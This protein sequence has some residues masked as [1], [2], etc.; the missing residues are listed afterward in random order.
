MHR[1]LPRTLFALLSLSATVRAGDDLDFFEKR[2]R[3][4]LVQRCEKCHGPD[5]QKGGLRL[6]SKAGWIRGGDRG[7]AIIPGKPDE[8]PLVRAVRHTDDDLAMP[9]H[10]AA[11]LSDGELTDLTD[12]VRRGAADPRGTV[13]TRL[14][15]MSL[16]EAKHW[17]S[18]QPLKRPDVP[19]S[20]EAGR[21]PIDAFLD[22]QILS[23]GITSTPRADKRTLIRRATFDLTGLPPTIEEVEAFQKDDSS[24]AFAKIVD[25]LLA[26]N[27]YGESWGRHWLDLVRYADTAGENTDHPLPHLWKY[28]NWVIS[29][30]NKDLPYDEFVRLQVAGDLLS[31]GLP[32][33][34]AADR[35]IAT[36]FLA[37][38]RRFGHD[39]DK[40]IHLT[41]EDAIDTTTKVFMG[42]TVGCARC[43]NHKYD[44]I[45]TEDYY[46]LYGILA[47]TRLPYPGCEPNPLP[48]N[49]VSLPTGGDAYAVAEGTI[50]DARMHQRGDPEKPGPAIPRRWLEV[51]GSEKVPPNSGSGR[52]ALA[53]W[54]STADNPLAARVMVNRIWQGHFGR[55]IVRT[56]SDFGSRG[57]PPTDPALL[58]WLASEFIASGWRI[59]SMHRRIMLSEAYQRSVGQSTDA[60][61][62]NAFQARFDRRRL[63]A[64]ELRDTLLLAANRLDRTPGGPH[65][66]P[67]EKDW[68]YTQHDPF[69]ASFPNDQR[70]VYQV[71]I[72]NRRD[73]YFSLFDGA[74][75]NTST[76]ERQDTTVPT[77]ALFFLNSKFVHEQSDRIAEL[78]GSEPDKAKRIDR[79]YSIL[80]QRLPSE[81]ERDRAKKFLTAYASDLP[82]PERDKAPW[83]ALSRVLIGSNEF[84]Y[85]D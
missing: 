51:L 53:G 22:K 43:H 42:L 68:H 37:A 5:K 3:P 45:S 9:P 58:D 29:S 47:S 25:R 39:I 16:D 12:W 80:L 11:K 32:P 4:V 54:L 15:G 44:P 40:D 46:A 19:V 74:D 83:A 26:S 27:S 41:I 78:L 84:L 1:L 50:G 49:L 76:S 61:P 30:F 82:E 67:P 17:W 18:L 10:P 7:P 73:P 81:S 65:P 13:A 6:D 55:G 8:S 2:I 60:D 63:T 71:V 14:G 24:E 38:A 72:R 34:E 79:L 66:F 69:A 64:E 33:E 75:P 35:T 48:K 77:Q 23:T 21:N 85:V 57:I 31:S 62:E 20:G 70:S 52:L 56:P 59:K 28:R 36:G